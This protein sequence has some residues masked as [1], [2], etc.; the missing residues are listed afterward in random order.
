MQLLR[1]E[2]VLGSDIRS[3]DSKT[4]FSHPPGYCTDVQKVNIT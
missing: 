1:I 4:R 3:I 2:L